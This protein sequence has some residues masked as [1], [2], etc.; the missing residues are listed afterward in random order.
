MSIEMWSVLWIG[1]SN[2]GLGASVIFWSHYYKRHPLPML[3]CLAHVGHF[4]Y[5][6]LAIV[7]LSVGITF[8]W[9]ALR[10]SMT[11][12]HVAV[13]VAIGVIVTIVGMILPNYPSQSNRKEVM[14]VTIDSRHEAIAHFVTETGLYADRKEKLG[15]DPRFE[16]GRW[17]FRITLDNDEVGIVDQIGEVTV[18]VKM[19]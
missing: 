1:I 5:F 10:G 19:I 4:G 2:L 15:A 14:E 6:V 16:G 9:G 12:N 18:R 13:S 8:V 11:M 17:I 3:G 7:F